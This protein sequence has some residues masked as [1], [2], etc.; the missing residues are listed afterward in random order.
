MISGIIENN[1]GNN[2]LKRSCGS[3]NKNFSNIVGNIEILNAELNKKVAS[4]IQAE[5]INVV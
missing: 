1:K 5:L 4:G 2:N 3:K